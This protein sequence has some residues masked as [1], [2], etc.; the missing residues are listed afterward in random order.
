M[1]KVSVPPVCQD[2]QKEVDFKA[3]DMNLCSVLSFEV[4]QLTRQAASWR[5]LGSAQGLPESDHQTMK[6]FFFFSK[7]FS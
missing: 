2:R 6:E 1:V 3:G 4:K 7:V 5:V